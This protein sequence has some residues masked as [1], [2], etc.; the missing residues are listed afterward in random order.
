MIVRLN[1]ITVPGEVF[2]ALYNT[3]TVTQCLDDREKVEDRFLNGGL[4]PEHNYAP[5]Q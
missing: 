1:Y 4:P 2:Y 3:K 5:L